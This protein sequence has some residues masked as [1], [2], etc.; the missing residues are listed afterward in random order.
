M[1]DTLSTTTWRIMPVS[2]PFNWDKLSYNLGVSTRR[3]ED[4]V[5]EASWLTHHNFL[6]GQ[7]SHGLVGGA[8][9]IDCGHKSLSYSQVVLDYFG[10]RI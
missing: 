7:T 3:G 6:E 9:S 10:Q 8:N 1:M 4:D 5:W 2:F